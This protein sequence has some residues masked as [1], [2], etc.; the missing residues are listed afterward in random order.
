MVIGKNRSLELSCSSTPSRCTDHQRVMFP[1]PMMHVDDE[2]DKVDEGSNALDSHQFAVPTL[3]AHSTACTPRASVRG[4][5]DAKHQTEK[6]AAQPGSLTRWS[7]ASPLL[8]P[9]SVKV[10]VLNKLMAESHN[11]EGAAAG[12]NG[13][14]LT[15]V[16]A[17]Q[18]ASCG[19]RCDTEEDLFR[20][21]DGSKV[22]D[23]LCGHLLSCTS[24]ASDSC[25]SELTGSVLVPTTKRVKRVGSYIMGPFL[26]EGVLGVVRD[27][28]DTSNNGATSTKFRRVAV[29][30][31]KFPIATSNSDRRTQHD[32]PPSMASQQQRRQSELQRL[33]RSEVQNLQR[34]SSTSVL[35]AIDVFSSNGTH[36]AVLPVAICNLEQLVAA[37]AHHKRC[38]AADSCPCR[39][40]FPAAFQS[41]E[42]AKMASNIVNQ[43]A[44]S[45]L[46]TNEFSNC[47]G[48]DMR[49]KCVPQKFVS[50]FPATVIR[51]VMRQLLSGVA[52]L[53]RQG[54]AHNDIKP[55]NILLFADGVVKIGD[56]ASVSAEYN[57]RG[58][59]LF[60]SPEVCRDF[61]RAGDSNEDGLT[62]VDPLKND[63]WACGV[64][65]YFLMTGYLSL[66]EHCECD[67]VYQLY[68]KIAEQTNPVNL[69]HVVDP[70]ESEKDLETALDRQDNDSVGASVEGK[71]FRPLSSTSLLRL[72]AGL[73]D[74][75]PN[76]RLT[77]EGAL[78]HPSLKVF[79]EAGNRLTTEVN[80]DAAVENAMR[81]VQQLPLYQQ[82]V[83]WD[84]RRHLQFTAECCFILGIR[85]PKS[86]CVKPSDTTSDKAGEGHDNAVPVNSDDGALGDPPG[87]VDCSLF[88]PRE[89]FDSHREASRGAEHAV[90]GL[91]RTHS[92]VER[93][94]EYL[95]G[96]MRECGYSMLSKE[97]LEG[98]ADSEHSSRATS[99]KECVDCLQGM[100]YASVVGNEDETWGGSDND[101]VEEQEKV[102]PGSY[103]RIM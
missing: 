34:F 21:L 4:I 102:K 41:C 97:C 100:Q 15:K 24:S 92:N 9:S 11:P 35:G 45:M 32:A 86:I 10:D 44:S 46:C 83:E 26:G 43:K 6:E 2:V 42:T 27:A 3:A 91:R 28:I 77:A 89:R 52:H 53:H 50:L 39:D 71:H 22:G 16:S 69:S 55:Q 87:V 25:A 80:D 40:T 49:K 38:A 88:Q 90:V 7:P 29:K 48:W 56:L 85:L 65:L 37:T 23:P 54:L 74:T 33:H 51:G 1:D 63:M 13:D 96:V 81:T 75:D 68:R 84:R 36:Y 30:C 19:E 17:F 59:P 61:Y 72:L 18:V 93:M 14:C 95:G 57:G 31:Y 62:P 5:S 76:T 12:E 8:V 98:G 66:F 60:L 58:T 82:F 67:N 73:L 103:C 47:R 99:V 70:P 64:V 78:R 101:L 94:K 20:H 79:K